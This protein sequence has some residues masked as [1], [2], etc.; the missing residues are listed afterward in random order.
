MKFRERGLGCLVVILFF[1]FCVLIFR[2]QGPLAELSARYTRPYV[3]CA[4]FTAD[5]A[6]TEDIFHHTNATLS[7]WITTNYSVTLNDISTDEVFGGYST[8]WNANGFRYRAIFETLDAPV[9]QILRSNW[10]NKPL[11]IDAARCFGDPT[12]YAAYY[13]QEPHHL[14]TIVDFVYPEEGLVF[15]S[16][17]LSG[18]TGYAEPGAASTIYDISRF[19]VL[20]T[21]EQVAEAIGQPWYL[22]EAWDKQSWADVALKEWQG[23]DSMEVV[24]QEAVRETPSRLPATYTAI[25]STLLS[26]PP[27]PLAEASTSESC[28]K[29]LDQTLYNLPYDMG[30]REQTRLV[31]QSTSLSMYG[32]ENDS[33]ETSQTGGQATLRWQPSTNGA[34]FYEAHFENDILEYVQITS[35]GSGFRLGDFIACLGEP[36]EAIVFEGQTNEGLLRSIYL[37]FTEQGI[38]TSTYLYDDEIGEMS[39]TLPVMMLFEAA[40]NQD[41]VALLDKAFNISEPAWR[42]ALQPWQ[43]W[44]ALEVQPHP[45]NEE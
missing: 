38:V 19:P 41:G 34:A 26:E 29:V 30:T 42:D 8:D 21:R 22:D 31:I 45:A 12:Y 3:N 32:E 37:F 7:N 39:D 23:W 5:P 44:E 13:Q 33:L 1:A 10:D 20:S 25:A 27:F 40:P 4:V 43:G 15:S 14:A 24:P 16:Y 9:S 2:F 28:Q 11:A 36:T 18:F 6:L 35:Y 17:D